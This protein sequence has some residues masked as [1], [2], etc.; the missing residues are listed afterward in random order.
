M[1]SARFTAQYNDYKHD[2]VDVETGAIGTGFKN[3]TFVY[4]GM[5]DQ[6][7]VGRYSGT[8]GFWGLHRDYKSI[9]DEAIAPPTTPALEELYNNGPHPGNLTFEIGNENLR[10]ESGDG[11]DFGVRHS[12]NRLRGEFNLFILSH[13]RF[14]IPCADRRS[15]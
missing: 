15:G 2:E 5:F 3:K 7:R 10:R 12:S 9:G 11:L 1:H 14:H 4:D 13:S 8:F 6:R